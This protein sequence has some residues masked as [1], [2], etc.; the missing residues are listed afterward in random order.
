MAK[1]LYRLGIA[2][3]SE[4]EQ[5]G[6]ETAR[7]QQVRHRERHDAA[8]GDNADR[9]RNLQSVTRHGFPRRLQDQV[10]LPVFSG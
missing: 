3:T 8:G 4:C 10:A 2:D 7:D 1:P 5:D 6:I 9:R